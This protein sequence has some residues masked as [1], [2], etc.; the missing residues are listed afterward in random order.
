MGEE[1][2]E[3]FTHF[4]SMNDMIFLSFIDQGEIQML[5]NKAL[6]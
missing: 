3:L 4:S 1:R 5:S 6:L 2:R